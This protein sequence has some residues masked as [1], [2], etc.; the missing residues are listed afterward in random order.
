MRYGEAMTR[1]DDV[2]RI[3]ESIRRLA[4]RGRAHHVAETSL[5]ILGVTILRQLQQTPDARAVDLA[6]RNGIDKS[7]ISRQLKTL[8]AH[9][10]VERGPRTGRDGQTLAITSAGEAA[11][12]HLA[13]ENRSRI[14]TRVSRWTDD[15]LRLL[16][17]L[18]ARLEE[19]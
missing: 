19:G 13:A 1:D 9:G 5:S 12:E 18:L 7:A 15:D 6:A 8:E 3:E 14:G 11:V 10:L 4:A 17:H 16:A 2:A